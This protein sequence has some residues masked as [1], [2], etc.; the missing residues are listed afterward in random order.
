MCS[1]HMYGGKVVASEQKTR[2]FKK[3]FFKTK[4]LDKRLELDLTKLSKNP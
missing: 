3:L 4:S 1:S 2:E